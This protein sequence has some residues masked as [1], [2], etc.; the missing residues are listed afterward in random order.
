MEAPADAV[1]ISA[2]HDL[3]CGMSPSTGGQFRLFGGDRNRL[4]SD[5]VELCWRR[6][7]L[8]APRVSISGSG[9]VFHMQTCG[10]AHRGIGDRLA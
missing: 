7:L 5:A 3:H 1:V 4:I 8:D 9:G 6:L 2:R 10:D